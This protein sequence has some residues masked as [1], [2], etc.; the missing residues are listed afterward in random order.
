MNWL[1]ILIGD[2]LLGPGTAAE[3]LL[4]GIAG[5]NSRGMDR[6]DRQDTGP[7]PTT[8]PPPSLPAGLNGGAGRP[9]PSFQAP[10]VSITPCRGAQAPGS[11]A[12]ISARVRVREL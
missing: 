10:A 8:R 3:G 12:K 9:P 11:A 7:P 6:L 2:L 5:Q 1:P 4:P